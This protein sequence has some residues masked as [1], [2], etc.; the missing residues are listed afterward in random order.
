MDLPSLGIIVIGGFVLVGVVLILVGFRSLSTSDASTRL[1]DFVLYQERMRVAQLDQTQ[2]QQSF[3]EPFLQR[4]VVAWVRRALAYLGQFTPQATIEK[5]NHQLAIIR[6]PNNIRAREFFAIRLL[7]MAVGLVIAVIINYPN[8]N[9]LAKIFNGGQQGMLASVA[10]NFQ[11][12]AMLLVYAGIAILIVLF[13]LPMAW[14]SGQVRKTKQEVQRTLPDALDMLSVCAD[15]GL[16]FDQAL[17]RVGEYM[18]NTIGAEFRRVVS[19]MEVGISRAD[20]LRNMS[21]RLDVAELSSFVSIIIQ[22]EE[23]G[24]RIADVL[25]SQAEQMRVIRQFKA[26]E[27]AYR[28]PAKM[29]IPLALLILPALLIVILG[30]LLPR[31]FD[32]LFNL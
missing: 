7:L 18:Q 29:V 1:D 16:G 9:Q 6:N 3:S 32:L 24:M 31:I 22:S 20:S 23:L 26:K 11:S 2:V 28:L 12:Q 15:A 30:P 27:I 14:L 13:L 21:N 17:Q 10:A 19:E 25:H 5:T 8:L 4:T